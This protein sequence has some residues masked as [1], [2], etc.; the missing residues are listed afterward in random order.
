MFC[1]LLLWV[2]ALAVAGCAQRADLPAGAA[3]YEIFP[4]APTETVL[5]EYRIHPADKLTVNVYREPEIS[6]VDV[7]VDSQGKLTVPLIG[8]VAA[9]GKTTDELRATITSELLRYLNDPRVVVFLASAAS[10]HVV[11]DGSVVQPGTYEFRGTTTLLGAIAMARGPSRVAALDEVA[12]F[13]RGNGQ[14]YAAKFNVRDIR[15]GRTP[16]PEILENDTV[17]VGF[18]GLKSAWQDLLQALPAFGI[19]R[20]FN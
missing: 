14:M 9:A 6:I 11:V 7:E 12:I 1:R 18:S 3:A 4:A 2:P 20:V 17:V 5:R 15:L 16:D 13:R 8:P 10:R 19:F